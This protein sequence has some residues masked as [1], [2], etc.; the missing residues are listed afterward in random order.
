MKDLIK[1]LNKNKDYTTICGSATSEILALIALRNKQ[2]LV[3]KNIKI[4]K[5]NITLFKEFLKLHS[6]KFV[7]ISP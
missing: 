5:E 3:E 2:N 4:I 7:F 1:E 6:D